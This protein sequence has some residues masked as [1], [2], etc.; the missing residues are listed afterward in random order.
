MYGL[1]GYDN[2]WLTNI[3]VVTLY[4]EHFHMVPAI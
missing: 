2:I 3:N 4:K 1:L